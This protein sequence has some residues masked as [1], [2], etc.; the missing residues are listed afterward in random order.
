MKLN[1]F[2]SHVHTNHSMD[3]ES[4]LEEICRAALEKG[5]TGVAVTDHY[6]CDAADESCLGEVREGFRRH[7]EWEIFLENTPHWQTGRLH[8]F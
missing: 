3:A 6:D 1:L 2:D 4:P 8:I 7:P 5:V